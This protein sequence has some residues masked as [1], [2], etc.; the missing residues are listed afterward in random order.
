MPMTKTP[1]LYACLYARELPAQA[2]LRERPELRDAPCVVLEGEPP[3]QTVCSLNTKARLL[4]ITHGMTRVEVETFP[5]AVVLNQSTL[6][7]TALKVILLET[8][9]AFSPRVEERR[10]AAGFLCAIDVSG[11]ESLFGPSDMLAKALLQRVRKL[12]ISARITVSRNFHTAACLAKGLPPRIQLQV[13]AAGN[14]ANALSM[15]PIT[16]LDLSAEQADTFTSWGIHTL[17]RL[18]ELPLK[19]LISRLGQDGKR[20]WQIARGELS[21][22]FQPVEPPFALTERRELDFPLDDLESLLFGVA[23]MLDQLILRATARILALASVTVELTLDGTGAHA[24]TVQPALPSND[25]HLW[26]K[27]LHHKLEASPPAASILG[28]TLRAQSG[29]TS[30]VQLGLF[31]PQLPEPGRLDIT[32]ARIAAVVG[33]GNVGR[34]V[35]EDTYAHENFRMEAFTVPSK[36]S[37]TPPS[38]GVRASLRQLRP[39]ER[40]RVALQNSAPSLFVFRE[41]RYTVERAY[42]PWRDSG[43]WWTTSLWGFEQW[44]LV[45]RAQD[46]ALLCCCLIRDLMQN[47]WQIAALY[48]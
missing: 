44:D 6:A 27:L 42:G 34:A 26:L 36:D 24:V 37:A 41:R 21:H 11:M 16:V 2:L 3:L 29:A 5:S 39:R 47:E 12:G 19:E 20:H 45:S 10:E 23:L 15:L 35:L 38:V 22:L 7:E 17:G 48:D 28:V 32:L 14:E 30:K 25:K 33:E 13:V 46:G 4:G 40:V 31:S 18:A 43:S 1:E 9:G 8:A